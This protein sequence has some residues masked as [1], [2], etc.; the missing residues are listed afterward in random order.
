MVSQF[1][2]FEDKK[3]AEAFNG[4]FGFSQR[5]VSFS[6]KEECIALHKQIFDE[7]SRIS[8][9]PTLHETFDEFFTA[10]VN[11]SQEQIRKAKKYISENIEELGE[12]L[13]RKEDPYA[14]KI[15]YTIITCKKKGS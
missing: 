10:R 2:S 14:W 5:E 1:G 9:G 7:I 12:A 13:V 15:P 8:D 4:I 11:A 6:G 3:Q